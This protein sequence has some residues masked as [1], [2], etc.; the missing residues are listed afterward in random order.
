MTKRR[1]LIGGKTHTGRL[2][3]NHRQR[4][5]LVCSV[6]ATHSLPPLE[7]PRVDLAKQLQQ[8]SRGS[9]DA[10]VLALSILD[11]IAKQLLLH[12]P[13]LSA[14]NLAN[15]VDTGRNDFSADT[16]VHK[17]L[18]ELVNDRSKYIRRGKL[19][20]RLRERYKDE[21]HA[22]LVVGQVPLGVSRILACEEHS[23][24]NVTVEAEHTELVKTHDSG[25]K[26]HDED[27]VL[28]RV[29]LV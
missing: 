25:Q 18:S 28:K 1:C 20:H 24:D 8:T 11:Q 21:S 10:L 19:V 23:L 14:A 9:R 6:D 2:S 22:D 29:L 17:L 16:G 15:G 13:W 3:L 12:A 4:R 26:L 27:L 7:Q 5:S